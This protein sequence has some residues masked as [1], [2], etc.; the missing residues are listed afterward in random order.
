MFVDGTEQRY[1]NIG[2]PVRRW[3]IALARLDEGELALV[4]QFFRAQKGVTGRFSFTDPVTG[5][6]YQNCSFEQTSL[7]GTFNGVN[8][9]AATLVI[10][11][12]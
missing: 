4:R 1:S 2:A 11:T 6:A 7:S 12:N 3:S 5:Q 8:N 10:R 9:T